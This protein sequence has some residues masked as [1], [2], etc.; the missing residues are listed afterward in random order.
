MA[1]S[2]LGALVFV[3]V[4]KYAGQ[5]NEHREPRAAH[6][7]KDWNGD[8]SCLNLMLVVD[9]GNDSDVPAWQTSVAPNAPFS[10]AKGQPVPNSSGYF[11]SEDA[12]VAAIADEKAYA[13][14]PV[15]APA[16]EV[17]GTPA[18]TP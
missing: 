2:M 8:G 14:A 11:T 12:V 15:A 13:A 7:A 6:V 5:S 9:G 3:G 1:K 10:D 17:P 18:S 16:I 4:T